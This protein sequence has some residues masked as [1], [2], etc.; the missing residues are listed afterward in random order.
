MVQ[1]SGGVV[2]RAAALAAAKTAARGA[3][4]QQAHANSLAERAFAAQQR[5]STESGVVRKGVMPGYKGHMPR[6]REEVGSSPFRS[7][8]GGDG[9]PL[10]G[11]G[12]K[13]AG[14]QPQQP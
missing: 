14:G 10:G 4:M 9:G 6:S 1:R 12:S 5:L 2:P 13:I 3:A 11:L 7:R 8:S